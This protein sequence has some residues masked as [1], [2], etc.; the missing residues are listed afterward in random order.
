MHVKC[1]LHHYGHDTRLPQAPPI[2]RVA[3]SETDCYQEEFY[4]DEESGVANGAVE[5]YYEQQEQQPTVS[6]CEEEIVVDAVEEEQAG[7]IEEFSLPPRP[8]GRPRKHPLKQHVPST[9]SAPLSPSIARPP[10]PPPSRWIP[11]STPIVD[12]QETQDDHAE[13]A[14]EEAAS[15]NQH[16]QPTRRSNRRRASP[17]KLR[18]DVA[19]ESTSATP[20][21]NSTVWYHE[22]S[23]SLQVR[24]HSIVYINW[25]L[26]VI[27][28]RPICFWE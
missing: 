10:S 5:E 28:K 23:A 13:T 20:A 16:L 24:N 2:G 4:N 22:I 7:V 3:Y 25:M 19:R 17:L 9:L 27:F 14:V 21:D 11:A 8:R 18:P 6:S 12:F 26:L 15:S 1:C